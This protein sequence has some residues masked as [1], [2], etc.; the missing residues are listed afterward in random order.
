VA[1]FGLSYQQIKHL[2]TRTAK[3]ISYQK[4]IK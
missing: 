4:F 3:T 2:S 1:D